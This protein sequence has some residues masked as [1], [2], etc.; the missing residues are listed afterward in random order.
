[1]RRRLSLARLRL[2]H[3]RH[4]QASHYHLARRCYP[5]LRGQ[6]CD[7][8]AT[9]RLAHA[10]LPIAASTATALAFATAAPIAASAT[11]VAV[12]WAN[13]SGVLGKPLR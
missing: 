2:H 11:C 9:K 4:W 8:G 6:R 7:H 10:I 13:A 5:P 12:D 3:A 1:M